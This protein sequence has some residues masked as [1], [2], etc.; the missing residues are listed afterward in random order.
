VGGGGGFM[1]RGVNWEK[2]FGWEF[3]VR[4]EGDFLVFGEFYCGGGMH[5]MIWGKGC[6]GKK[7]MIWMVYLFD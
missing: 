6:C 3:I 7:R 5:S 1:Q 2:V 4:R